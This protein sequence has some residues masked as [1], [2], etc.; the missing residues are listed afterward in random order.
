MNLGHLVDPAAAA[1]VV[2]GTLV[3]TVLRAGLHD[4][5]L[6]LRALSELFRP[7]F[8]AD[9]VRGEVATLASQIRVDGMFRARPRHLGDIAFDEATDAMIEQRSTEALFERHA[10]HA[11]ARIES[12]VAAVRTLTMAADLGPVFGLA[13]TL[14]SLS[15][16]P[17]QGIA[18]SMFMGAISMSVLTT[19]YGLLFA[20]LVLAPLGRA[21]ERRCERE[22]ADRQDITEWLA[23]Q[24]QRVLPHPGPVS[25]HAHAQQ[26]HL[27]GH[28]AQPPHAVD[29]REAA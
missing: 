16:L 19:L 21:V 27:Q 9:T 15:N 29:P 10:F 1:I 7:A 18:R 3:A 11:R 2:G 23:A 25:F 28:F 13:G 22:E 6:T 24:V 26:Q 20:N 4:C 5:G 14:V 8:D 12:A 17:S